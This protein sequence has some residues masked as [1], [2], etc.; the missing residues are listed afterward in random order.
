MP[1]TVDGAIYCHPLKRL[2]RLDPLDPHH[3]IHTSLSKCDKRNTHIQVHTILTDGILCGV[4]FC[5]IFSS[6]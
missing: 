1:S 3:P 4:Y 5:V 2:E 6:G